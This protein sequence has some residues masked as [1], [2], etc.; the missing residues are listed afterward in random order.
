[1]NL[2]HIHLDLLRIWRRT[3]GYRF[4]CSRYSWSQQEIL[5]S[6]AS[7]EYE[8]SY[9]VSYNSLLY[10]ILTV[11]LENLIKK[12]YNL[13][14]I[15]KVNVTGYFVWSLLDNF[16][17]QDG[18]KNRFGL[19]YIDFKNNL[20]RYEKESGKYYKEFLSQG[21]RPSMINR[22]ELWAVFWEFVLM[23]LSPC[24]PLWLTKI[25]EV[26]VIIIKNC[27]FISSVFTLFDKIYAA[28]NLGYNN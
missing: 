11:V 13:C 12:M 20:T 27:L 16:E 5:S 4:S 23:S 10:D 3:W 25:D 9:L 2:K 1:M 15:D 24:I 18:Y 28:L 8:W 17:W 22:D 19:Y 14:S 26:L 7:F 21:V 6:E